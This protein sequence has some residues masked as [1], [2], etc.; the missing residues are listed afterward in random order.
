MWQWQD[1]L[2]DIDEGNAMSCFDMHDLVRSA[3]L[4]LALCRRR[5]WRFGRSRVMLETIHDFSYAANG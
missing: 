2:N 1:A 4:F 5:G 3:V